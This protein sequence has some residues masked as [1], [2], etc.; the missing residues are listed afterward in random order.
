MGRV[1]LTSSDSLKASRR[2][3]IRRR[4]EI[5]RL[6][7]LD[8]SFDNI[9]GDKPRSISG[10]SAGVCLRRPEVSPISSPV[11]KPHEVPNGGSR[12]REQ[13]LKRA[14]K[15]LDQEET[16]ASFQRT[17]PSEETIRHESSEEAE[18]C[19]PEVPPYPYR[20]L[21]VSQSADIPT[22]RSARKLVFNC[23]P[24]K[25]KDESQK[26]RLL[27][28]YNQICQAYQLLCDPDER[29]RYDE[30]LRLAHLENVRRKEARDHIRGLIDGR[31]NNDDYQIL[32]VGHH[33]VL[34]EV[35]SARHKLIVSCHPENFEDAEVKV[36]FSRV[37]RCIQQA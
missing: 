24:D 20:T 15:I 28:Q 7:S 36:I 5:N 18:N 35:D 19:P 3:V 29:A 23:H 27:D 8:F 34:A 16:L 22:I 14:S 13:Y 37:C 21:G 31:W 25:V 11:S 26:S 32:G 6:T 4:M 30:K 33:A 10:E 12:E 17:S 2:P 1:N 9:P